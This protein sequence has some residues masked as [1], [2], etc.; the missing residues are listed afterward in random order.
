MKLSEILED[1][2]PLQSKCIIARPNSQWFTQF[3]RSQKTVRRRYERK[4]NK[5]G[6]DEDKLKYTKQCK[7]VNFLVD[8]GKSDFLKQQVIQCK[9]DVK[10]L[11]STAKRMLN[12]QHEPAYPQNILED[13]MPQIFADYFYDK[14][15]RINS[16]IADSI[17]K[18]AV[19]E[20]V[21]FPLSNGKLEEFSPASENEIKD[22]ISSLSSAS[23]KLDP[24]PASIVK[25]CPSL[26]PWITEI[27]NKSLKSMRYAKISRVLDSKFRGTKENNSN[28]SITSQVHTFL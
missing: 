27:V 12:W 28:T 15:I 18:E 14:I 19:Q 25:N 17:V 24:L 3:I 16:T 1:Y 4:K 10:A 2:A 21:D 8:E 5:T 6:L 20:M 22:I 26:I 23:C 13:H 9:E 11:F 7:Y